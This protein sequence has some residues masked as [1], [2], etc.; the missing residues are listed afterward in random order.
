M[1]KNPNQT[2]NKSNQDTNKKTDDNRNRQKGNKQHNSK[3]QKNNQPNKNNHLSYTTGQLKDEF[4]LRERRLKLVYRI[5]YIVVAVWAALFVSYASSLSKSVPL[6]CGLLSALTT[7]I[8]NIL[9][10]IFYELRCMK[11]YMSAENAIKEL[12]DN[13]F[14]EIWDTFGLS[15]CLSIFLAILNLFF[16]SIINKWSISIAIFISMI[17]IGINSFLKNVKVKMLIRN[18]ATSIICYAFFA[19]TQLAEVSVNA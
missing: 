10:Y 5:L 16:P 15:L 17:A 19:V 8:L 11:I 6:Y 12:A 14:L 9:Y 3:N 18:I 1:S 4:E 13:R 7:S 2:N